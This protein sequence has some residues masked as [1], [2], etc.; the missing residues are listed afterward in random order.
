MVGL[1]HVLLDTRGFILKVSGEVDLLDELILPWSIA[2]AK[3]QILNHRP[4]T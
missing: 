1:Q 4:Q 2:G 3:T